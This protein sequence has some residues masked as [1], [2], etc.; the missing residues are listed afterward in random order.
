MFKFAPPAKN[1]EELNKRNRKVN[2]ICDL[3]LLIVVLVS[4]I[5]LK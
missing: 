3:V 2:L 4:L 1:I 5:W